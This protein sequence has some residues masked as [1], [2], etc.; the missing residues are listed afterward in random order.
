MAS[1]T[2]TG[3][4]PPGPMDRAGEGGKFGRDSNVDIMWRGQ[5][6][7]DDMEGRR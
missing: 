2:M 3:K 1:K 6:M 7:M 5:G 4:A